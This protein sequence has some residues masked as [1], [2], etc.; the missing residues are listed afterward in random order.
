MKK[1]DKIIILGIVI[2]SLGMFLS[3]KLINSKKYDNLYAEI[4]IDNVLNRKIEMV[5]GHNEQF[6][7]SNAYGKNVIDV[8]GK[9]I[10]IS[11]ADCP[12]KICVK[13]GFISK[14]GQMIVCL[15]H[16]L[17]IEIKGTNKVNVD[18]QSY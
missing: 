13:D 12:D 15:P 17:I 16:K 6:T 2:L 18:I 7:I 11:D 5:D 10:R 8:Q 3:Y 14:S 4:Y 9:K 1:L